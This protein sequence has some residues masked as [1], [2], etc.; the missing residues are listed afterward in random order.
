[1]DLQLRQSGTAGEH[2]NDGEGNGGNPWRWRAAVEGTRVGRGGGE[3]VAAG[4]ADWGVEVFGTWE[5]T[6]KGE[7]AC[8]YLTRYLF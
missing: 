5:S 8:L 6:R 3:R 2:A 1:M 4:E 7:K